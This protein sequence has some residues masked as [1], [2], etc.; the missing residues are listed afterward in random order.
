MALR[1]KL[2]ENMPGEAA[3]SLRSAGHDVRTVL[4]QRLGGRPDADVLNVCRDEGRILVTLDIGFGDI[5]SYPPA[6][7]AGVWVVR[8][9]TQGMRRSCDCSSRRSRSR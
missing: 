9:E 5:Q 6:S 1:F 8:A 4:E 7:H 3:V 2:D